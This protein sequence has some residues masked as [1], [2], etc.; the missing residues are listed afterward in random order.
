MKKDTLYGPPKEVFVDD[1]NEAKKLKKKRKQ[2]T[3][4]PLA[5]EEEQVFD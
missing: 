2:V 1:E 3:D 5:V 4:D